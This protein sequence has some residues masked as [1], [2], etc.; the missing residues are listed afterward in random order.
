MHYVYS[1]MKINDVVAASDCL[2]SMST[3]LF[4][5]TIFFFFK[6]ILPPQRNSRKCDPNC[7]GY[8]LISRK[9]PLSPCSPSHKW[10][11][12]VRDLI[13]VNKTWRASMPADLGQ[14]CPGQGKSRCDLATRLKMNSTQRG[15]QSQANYTEANQYSKKKSS[16]SIFQ[17]FISGA[18][19]ISGTV[20]WR[21]QDKKYTPS[22]FPSPN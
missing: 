7:R 8:I 14:R 2:T 16:S 15:K 20:M 13:L 10:F 18:V 21:H 22:T 17:C 12:N 1:R 19:C 11:G 6:N 3:V 5:P 4:L 9:E